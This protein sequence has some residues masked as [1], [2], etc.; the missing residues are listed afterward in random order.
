MLNATVND[1]LITWTKDSRNQY[2]DDG[3]NIYY[4]I[5]I[6]RD[7]DTA[8]VVNTEGQ[9][10]ARQFT[11]SQDIMIKAVQIRK[12]NNNFHMIGSWMEAKI[13]G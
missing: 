13:N 2:N 7:D 8:I 3:V 6:I 9:T 4:E 12:R 1:H 11:V 10:N 5:Q